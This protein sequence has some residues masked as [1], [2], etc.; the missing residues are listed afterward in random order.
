MNVLHGTGIDEPLALPAG[1]AISY[2][3]VDGLG[4]VVATNDAA[5][6]VTHSVAF[7]AWGE[8]RR[9]LGTR[10]HPFTYT[11]RE[12]GELGLLFYRARYYQP[13]V[14]RF[15]QEDPATIRVPG[16]NAEKYASRTREGSYRYSQN[17]P[18]M[19]RD[20]LGLASIS[21]PCV[22]RYGLFGAAAGGLLGAAAGAAAGTATGLLGVAGG[23]VVVVTVPGGAA[24]GAVAGAFSGAFVGGA[25]GVAYGL[26]VCSCPTAEDLVEKCKETCTERWEQEYDAC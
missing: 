21:V 15:T 25:V 26:H 17:S 2:V 23:P 10:T 14:G 1:R 12:T 3:A 24:A 18:L 22:L 11:G 13:S 8:T 4:R 6:S 16:R 5:G 9:E 19:R 20:P 7:D